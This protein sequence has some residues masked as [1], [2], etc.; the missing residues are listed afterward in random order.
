MRAKRD[1][2]HYSHDQCVCRR[3][4]F[5]HQGIAHQQKQRREDEIREPKRAPDFEEI[6]RAQCQLKRCNDHWQQRRILDRFDFS[7]FV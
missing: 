5:S 2:H 3:Q 1:G 4:K 7:W 6:G